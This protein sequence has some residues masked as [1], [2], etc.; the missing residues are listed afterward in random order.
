MTR[1]QKIF[2]AFNIAALI[3]M[4]AVIACAQQ[5]HHPLHEDFYRHWMTPD[6]PNA[7][8]CDARVTVDGVEKGDCEPTKAKMV[9]DA[10]GV[11]RWFA[12][13]RQLNAYVP[14]PDAKIL[15][16]RNPNVFDAHVCWTPDRGIICFVPEDTGG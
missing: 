4:W 2:V 10:E 6:N 7:S 12:Y 8:C 1:A 5:P 9:K 15:R 11:P 3:F 13:I 16:E 14:V